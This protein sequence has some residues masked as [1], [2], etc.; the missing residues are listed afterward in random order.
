MLVSQAVRNFVSGYSWPVGVCLVN[1]CALESVN[2]HQSNSHLQTAVM[3]VCNL[4]YSPVQKECVQYRWLHCLQY[5]EAIGD[6]AVDL[7]PETAAHR[8][9]LNFIQ[10]NNGTT[11]PTD[12]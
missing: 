6:P 9:D 11:L 10:W 5:L 2:I 7:T 12:V 8:A 3:L 1:V 4:L